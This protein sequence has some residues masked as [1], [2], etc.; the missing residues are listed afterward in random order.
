M[1]TYQLDLFKSPEES[2]MDALRKAFKDVKE[3]TD[4]VR[5]KLF[6]ENG[7]L[8]KQITDLTYRMEVIER[9][10]CLGLTLQ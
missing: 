7:K 8:I 6:A 3:S 4:R 2:E 1:I 10:I 5:K 9:N